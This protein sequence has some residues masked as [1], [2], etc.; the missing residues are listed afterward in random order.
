MPATLTDADIEA[1]IPRISNWGRWGADDDVGTL[2][3]LTPDR[4][5][6]AAK[7]VRSGEAVSMARLVDLGD[8]SVERGTHEV[9]QRPGGGARDYIGLVFH[10]FTVTH[11]DSPA[12]AGNGNV[13]YNEHPDTLHAGRYEHGEISAGAASTIVG[14]GVLLDVAHVRG[15]PLDPG[16]AIRAQELDECSATLGV[17]IAA[18]D[19]LW[20]RTGLGVRN[21]R[22]ARAG[23][24]AD[25]LEWLRE[26][27]IALLGS[28]GD[29]DVAP[30]SLEEWASPMH[31]VGILHL[32]LALV[33]NAE[34]EQLSVACAQ[35]GR[36]EFLNLV[37]P[38][39]LRGATGSPVNPL[40]LL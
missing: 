9:E 2:N 32:G 29:N 37:Q 10:G 17:E 26:Q 16:E 21:T 18:G 14:R 31:S 7:L 20:V 28:D 6:E 34:L 35:A 40:A 1:L 38:L 15:R 27:D 3:L 30:S 13:M 36:W 19:L 5:R 11:L 23:L 22:A 33:D 25:C 8:G 12:H 24:D 4:R 39:P